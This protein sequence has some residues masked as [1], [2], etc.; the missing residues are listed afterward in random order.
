MAEHDMAE[1]GKIS[2]EELNVLG[3]DGFVCRVGPVFEHSPW[4]AEAACAKKPVADS[5]ILRHAL[6]ETVD[7]AADARKLALIRAHD[8]LAGRAP[9]TG[10]LTR[11][12]AHE[13]TAAGLKR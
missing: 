13:Q 2:L 11:E 4:I 1:S 9:L 7:N 3:Q 8:D 12:S 6:C 5:E 10:T